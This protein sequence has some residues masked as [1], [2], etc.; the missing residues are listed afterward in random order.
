V[1]ANATCPLC[2]AEVRSA[3]CDGRRLA[4]DPDVDPHGRYG[5]LRS[6]PDGPA[7]VRPAEPSDALRYRRHRCAPIDA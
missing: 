5:L 2:A 4:L 7:F 6:L 1:K 3:V